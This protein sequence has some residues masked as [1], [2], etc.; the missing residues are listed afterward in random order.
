[1]TPHTI[2]TP[3]TPAAPEQAAFR[4]VMGRFATGV[5]AVTGLAEGSPAGLA[6][7][8]FTSVSLVPPLVSFCVAR[9]SRTW[10]RI[11]GTGLVCINILREDQ[12]D[13]SRRMA[14]AGSDKF[15]GLAWSASP[16]GLPLIDG[17]IGWLE[18]AL[19]DEHPAGDHAIVVTRVRHL[20]AREADRP[21]L[22]YR[23]GYGRLAT[24][25]YGES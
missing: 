3:G 25:P 16:S 14:A 1:M 8:S 4:E 21:L 17:A 24:L 9:T 22:F 11:R 10:P 23:G 12:R 5:V 13:V 15:R 2:R 6:V 20:G 19:D 18:C 7:N